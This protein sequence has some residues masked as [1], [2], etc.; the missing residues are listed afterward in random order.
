VKNII[1]V[2][3]IVKCPKDPAKSITP[4]IKL[5]L[6]IKELKTTLSLDT[7]EPNGI[8]SKITKSAFVTISD[9]IIW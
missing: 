1:P 7:L 6:P 3:H 5:Q 2:T 9:V 4:I 8:W